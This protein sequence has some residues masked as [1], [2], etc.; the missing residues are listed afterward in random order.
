MYLKTFML[1]SSQ[2]ILEKWHHT[3]S[4]ASP[5]KVIFCPFCIPFSI[6][7]SNIFLSCI[8]FCPL[9]CGHLSFSWITSPAEN[10][11][12]WMLHPNKKCDKNINGS[13]LKRSQELQSRNRARRDTNLILCSQDKHAASV[14]SCLVQ[15]DKLKLS[16]QNLDMEHIDSMH[17]SLIPCCKV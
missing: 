16:C 3:A 17:L 7:T 10:I 8:T 13:K 15:A 4:S 9:H 12:P 6:W 5:W 2:S 1:Q 14:V 11:P